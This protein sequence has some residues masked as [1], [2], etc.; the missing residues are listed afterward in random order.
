VE[1][2]LLTVVA[3][4]LDFNVAS[5]GAPR[6][7][8]LGLIAFSMGLQNATITKISGAVVRSTHLTGVVTDFGIE[9]VQFGLWAWDKLRG[10]FWQ[11][12]GRLLR[13]SQRHPTVLRLALLASIWVSFFLGAIVGTLLFR[14]FHATAMTVPVA[15]L[16]FIVIQDWRK[17][18]ADIREIDLLSDPELKLHGIVHTLL[19]PELGVYRLTHDRRMNV[20]APNFG[21][22]IDRL[23]RKKQVIILVMSPVMRFSSNSILDL[24]AAVEKLE[25]SGR[26][27]II[28]GVNP[29]QYK[30]LAHEHVL[31][32]V[33][34]ENVCPDIEFAIALGSEL[35]R[36]RQTGGVRGE[37][38]LT[39]FRALP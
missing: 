2:V 34:A 31:D 27:L 37:S 8:I 11:R 26:R 9:S 16:V 36:E 20:R 22:W 7:E 39:V 25:E 30:V 29:V 17:P 18:I 19:P 5:A 32:H 38:R 23:P 6:L 21:P 24:K 3:L 33:G 28:A 13:V 35:V 1:A 12:G 4:L 10:R 15:F 14:R